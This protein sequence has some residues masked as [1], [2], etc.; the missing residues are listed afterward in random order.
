MP[1]R[2]YS[3]RASAANRSSRSSTSFLDVSKC[4]HSASASGAAATAQGSAVAVAA[5]LVPCSCSCRA[6]ACWHSTHSEFHQ[7]QSWAALAVAAMAAACHLAKAF[8][9]PR[10]DS[11]SAGLGRTSR[12]YSR[13]SS[14]S[15]SAAGSAATLARTRPCPRDSSASARS[16][17][18][19]WAG[20]RSSPCCCRSALPAAAAG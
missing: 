7:I 9:A 16:S 6:W 20:R 5:R 4:L 11:P 13:R 3:S 12:N 19:G 1:S 18:D 2:D 8:L 10:K 14:G 15:S 17:S